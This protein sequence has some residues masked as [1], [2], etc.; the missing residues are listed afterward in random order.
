MC[1]ELV[2]TT[3]YECEHRIDQS[4]FLAEWQDCGHCGEKKAGP[5]YLAYDK[6]GT[7]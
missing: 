3:K 1:K 5:E 7:V 6:K 2:P 4:S